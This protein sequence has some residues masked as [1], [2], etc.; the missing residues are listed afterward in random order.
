VDANHKEINDCWFTNVNSVAGGN[1]FGCLYDP[2][3]LSTRRGYPY[4][5]GYQFEINIPNV[6]LIDA[7][8]YSSAAWSTSEAKKALA[9]E[10]AWEPAPPLDIGVGNFLQITDGGGYVNL[11]LVK[12]LNTFELTPADTLVYGFDFTAPGEGD[13][14]NILQVLEGLN[15]RMREIHGLE[16]YFDLSKVKPTDC[17]KTLTKKKNNFQLTLRIIGL[18]GYDTKKG[19]VADFIGGYPTT[20]AA[21]VLTGK[22]AA[23]QWTKSEMKSFVA[24]YGA[25]LK[26]I[27]YTQIATEAT[28][29]AKDKI[30]PKK[31]LI[32]ITKFPFACLWEPDVVVAPAEIPAEGFRER[33][34]EMEDQEPQAYNHTKRKRHR[35]HYKKQMLEAND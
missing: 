16:D 30:L 20:V 8:T 18:C 1:N 33:L 28:A 11:P 6:Y 21:P 15:D 31:K 12:I 3:S 34:D 26:F 7:L 35:K 24:G 4:V 10:L 23:K 29:S 14:Y 9:F 25:F 22:G 17:Y 5:T 27:F 19:V 32:E 2:L 13:T